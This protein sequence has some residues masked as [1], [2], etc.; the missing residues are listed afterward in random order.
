MRKLQKY[1]DDFLGIFFPNLCL[2]C[3]DEHPM[4]DDILCVECYY[5]LP[6][7]GF[8]LIDKNQMFHKL[9]GKV[10]FEKATALYYFQKDGPTQKLIHNLK[11]DDQINVGTYLGK[12]Y[13]TILKN[14]EWCQDIDFIIPVP[15]HKRKLHKRGYN[16]SQLIAEGLS[17]STGIPVSIK[18]L[19]RVTN[20]K[21]QTKKNLLERLYNVESVFQANPRFSLKGMHILIVDDVMTTGATL[22]SCADAIYEVTKDVKISFVSMLYVE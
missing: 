18:A 5:G 2:A 21:S 3:M 16:Q 13:G 1:L 4:Q 22:V 20:S 10:W 19:L 8:H 9:A 15:L 11:Y 17:E 7:T 6:K 12:Y 14:S